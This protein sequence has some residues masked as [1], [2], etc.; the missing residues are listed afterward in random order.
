VLGALVRTQ[1]CPTTG[2]IAVAKA[3]EVRAK[4]NTGT[5]FINDQIKAYHRQSRSD[6]LF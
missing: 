4:T 6:N 3:A 1:F 5:V 2:A